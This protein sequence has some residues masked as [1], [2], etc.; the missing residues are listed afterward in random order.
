MTRRVTQTLCIL[1]AGIAAVGDGVADDIDLVLRAESDWMYHGF[2]EFRGQ[3]A[4][5]LTVDWQS[6]SPIFVGAS[7]AQVVD[8][9]RV[10]RPTS[11]TYY[12]GAGWAVSDQVFVSGA[13]QHRDFPGS[14]GEW[15]YQE[16]ELQLDA[17]LSSV[18]RL[19]VRADYADDYY[20][21]DASALGAEVDYARQ[22]DDRFYGFATIGAIRFSENTRI[23][24]Y[25]YGQLG[26]GLRV[27]SLTIDLALRLNSESSET[28][29]GSEPFSDREWVLRFAWQ[30]L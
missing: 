17:A 19:I 12:I 5:G 28:R 11:G 2:S 30:A 7:V 10:R 8:D 15:D 24:N 1:A 27:S 23:P 9:E 14:L 22:L 16:Y 3:P 6:D 4:V 21:V 26:V 29:I 25:E 13:F 18:S 20:S